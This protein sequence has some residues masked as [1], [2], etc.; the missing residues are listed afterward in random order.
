MSGRPAR[1]QPSSVTGALQDR[2]RVGPLVCAP[3]YHV[4]SRLVPLGL[5]ALKLKLCRAATG[6]SELKRFGDSV[7][8]V[9]RFLGHGRNW[10]TFF[11]RDTASSLLSIEGPPM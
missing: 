5:S 3:A 7:H 8:Q 10:T 6:D 11:I 9:L 2:I 1:A 4:V